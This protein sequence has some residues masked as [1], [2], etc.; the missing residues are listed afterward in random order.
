MPGSRQSTLNT[1]ERVSSYDVDVAVICVG[2]GGLPAAHMA[3]NLGGR[4]AL[5]ERAGV[6][7]A[8]AMAINATL[9]GSARLASE[10]ATDRLAPAIFSFRSHTDV[11]V[12]GVL[13][14]GV[15]VANLRLRASTS[16]RLF[17]VLA[18]L[19]LMGATVALLVAYLWGNDPVALAFTAA[20]YA[21]TAGAHLVFERLRT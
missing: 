12:A 5:I 15:C 19:V 20:V 14:I 7:G 11:P 17:P 6:G 4:V 10:I 13:S 2:Q 16:S 9:F 21:V 8:R 1:G 18:G 3:A